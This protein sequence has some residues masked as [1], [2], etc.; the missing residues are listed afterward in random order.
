MRSAH[1]AVGKLVR[2]CEERK[3]RLVELPG[4]A[5]DAIQPGLSGKVG[6]VL[7]VKNALAA[8]QSFGSTAPAAGCAAAGNVLRKKA[9]VRVARQQ[10]RRA[11]PQAIGK[12]RLDDVP[13]RHPARNHRQHVLLIRRQHVQHVRHLAVE[14]FLEGIVEVALLR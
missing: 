11:K 5:F 14:H 2:L 10:A 8:F 12:S 7:G 4:E 13:H 3:C 1:E 6:A 9:R